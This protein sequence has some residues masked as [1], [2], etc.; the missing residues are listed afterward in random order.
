MKGE[1]FIRKNLKRIAIC[2]CIFVFCISINLIIQKYV[3]DFENKKA[4]TNL[5]KII[6]NDVKEDYKTQNENQKN[7]KSKINWNTLNSINKDIVG[8]IEIP[9]TNIN[10]P[11]LKDENLYYLNHNFERKN[12]KNG[13]IFIRNQDLS[14]DMEIEIY[15]HNMKNGTMFANLSKFM[16]EDFFE[17]NSKIYIYTKE[18]MFEGNIFAV[19]TKNVNEESESIKGLN[20]Y[21]KLEYYKMQ[22]VN[23]RN[24]EESTHKIIKLVTCSYINAKT[25]PTDKRY[26]VIAQM[27]RCN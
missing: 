1:M 2:V 14:K 25:S 18:T 27:N 7:I 24:I 13:S 16:N 22:S 19:Y 4:N 11:I 3:Q 26:Y 20:L 23:S 12:N 17:K 9:D 10:Y 15:G 21:E 5:V 8:W 6:T